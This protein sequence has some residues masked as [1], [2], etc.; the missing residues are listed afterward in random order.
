MMD[1][2]LSVDRAPPPRTPKAIRGPARSFP[3]GE[4]ARGPHFR[5]VMPAKARSAPCIH[6]RPRPQCSFSSP[7][8]QAPLTPD[9]GFGLRPPRES[10]Q[11]TARHL[12]G[13][14]RRSG[15][16]RARFLRARTPA[17][18]IFAASCRRRQEAPL[19]STT[20]QGFGP[21]AY[22]GSRPSPGGR[23]R[24]RQ[25]DRPLFPPAIR[26]PRAARQAPHL[27]ACWR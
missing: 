21:A 12:P 2:A 26:P 22:R 13:R 24:W 6:D 7:H 14:R 4:D 3:A 16:P 25:L 15:A 20:G 23:R 5:S 19:A 27:P 17:V 10:G 9:P 1:C 8:P 18:R 11:W